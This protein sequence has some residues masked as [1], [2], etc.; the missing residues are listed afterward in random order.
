MQNRAE[1]TCLSISPIELSPPGIG[2]ATARAGG[3]GVLDLEFC[4][5]HMF[6]LARTNLCQLL[7]LTRP[8]QSIGLRLALSRLD[9]ATLDAFLDPLDGRAQWLVLCHWQPNVL[10]Q[11][12]KRLPTSANRRILLE[13]TTATQ[14]NALPTLP[15]EI[16]GLL[17]KGNECGGWVGEDSAFV[18]TQKLL[19]TSSL[20]VYVQ[21][22][23]GIHTAAACRGGGAAGVV[24]DDGLWLMPE[25]P[26][27]E[28]WKSVL[29]TSAGQDT[30]AFGATN[31]VRVL[32][33]PGFGAVERLQALRDSLPPQDERDWQQVAGQH[34]GWGAPDALA[35]PVGQ[36]I[37][38][39][40]TLRQRYKTT[41][42][43]LRALLDHSE[44]AVRLGRKLHVLGPGGPLASAHATTYPILQGPMT[45]VSDTERFA[46][47]VAQAGALPLLALALMQ[48]PA[49][50]RLLNATKACLGDRPWGVGIL[51]FVPLELRQAQLEVVL[52]IRPHIAL[53][54]GG[55]PDQALALEQQGIPTYL[56]VPAP[57]LARL[58]VEQGAKRLIF[59]G[60]ECGGHV[61]PLGSF[62]LWDAVVGTLLDVVP[63][64]AASQMHLLFAGGIHDARSARMIEALSAPLAARGMK[65]G[66]LMGTAYL[67]TREA[68][69]SG[70]IASGFQ[71]QAIA[72]TRTVNLETGPGHASR[73]ALTPFA[74]TFEQTGRRLRAEGLN[75]SEVSQALDKLCLG[76]LRVAAKG[77]TR[78]G[79]ALIDVAPEA[80]LRD[81]MYMIG[82][83]ATM[84]DAVISIADLHRAVCERPA[85]EDRA[86]RLDDVACDT[87][88]TKASDIAIIGI[89]TILPR[90]NSP[91]Q[92]WH[93]IL[94]QIDAVSEIPAARWDWRL[95][96][97]ADPKKRDKV[98]SKWG[99]FIDEVPFNPA[100][101]G[102]PPKSLP[103]IDPI[104]LLAL[105]AVRRAL[106]DAGYLDGDFDRENTAVILGYSGGIGELGEHYV[107][108]SELTARF[109][110]P[111][112]ALLA[113][114]PEWTEDS[115]PGILP[116]VSAGRVTNRF[117]LGGAN[118][119][120]DSA[121]ASSLTAID[122]AVSQLESGRCNLAIA[123]GVDTKLS[124]FGYLCF[125]KTPA[126]TPQEHSHPFDSDADGILLG[127]GVAMVILKRLADAEA[128][129][130]R[131]Y[132][133]IK[134]AASSSDGKALGLTAPRSR[135]Q[136]KA[137]ERAYRKAGFG[138]DAIGLYEAHGTGTRLGDETELHS[139]TSIL[140]AHHA[141]PRSCAVGSVKALIGHTKSTAGAAALIK[142]ALSLYSRTLPPQPHVR[143][144]LANLSDPKSPVY[145][146]QEPIPWLQHTDSPRRAGVSA[147]GFGGTNC[148]CV[149]EEYRG[150]LHLSAPGGQ[151]WPCEL[152]LLA[153][154]GRDALAAQVARLH[155]RLSSADTAPRLRDI[156]RDCVNQTRDAG[157]HAR[158][159]L[160]IVAGDMAALV[161]ALAQTRAHLSAD[162]SPPLPPHIQ[163]TPANAPTLR[164]PGRIAFL[165]PGQGAQ[166]LNMAREVTLLCEPLRQSFEA[167]DQA[168]ADALTQPI[169]R[170]VFPRG[171]HGDAEQA[172]ATRALTATDIAQPAIGVVEA[173]YLALLATLG[174]RPDM[175]GGHSYGEYAAL[176]AA[177]VLS[178]QDFLRLSRARGSAMAAAGIAGDGTMAVV[179][180]SREEVERFLA[181]TEVVLANHNAPQ[182][183]VISGR[184]EAVEHVLSQMHAAGLSTR[185]LPV[186]GAFHS[187][188]MRD[189][190]GILTQAIVEVAMAR[191]QIPVYSNIDARPYPHDTEAIR[192]HLARHMLSPV[193]FVAQVNSMHEAGARCFVEVGPKAILTSLVNQIL[194][195]R[196]H[197]AVSVDGAG[198]GLR[199]LLIALGTLFVHGID[200][201]ISVL[202]EARDS[203]PS[204][205]QDQPADAHAAQARSP[206]W[207]V[208]GGGV[209]RHDQIAQA[210]R[211]I[212]LA[213]TPPYIPNAL[214]IPAPMNEQ[215]NP[216]E[217][218]AQTASGAND[219]MITGTRQAAPFTT[220]DATVAAY[221][222]YQE[223]MQQFLAVQERVM[224]RFLG[225]ESPASVS[226]PQ[227][228]TIPS[229]PGPRAHPPR[230][231]TPH[232]DEP[233]PALTPTTATP[234]AA[235]ALDHD[236]LIQRLLTVVSECTGYPPDMLGLDQALEAELG[237]DSIKRVEILAG[238]ER[239]LPP[240]L[241]T[242]MSAHMEQASRAGTINALADLLLRLAPAD[243]LPAGQPPDPT[244]FP[245]LD[246]AQLTAQV[247]GVVSECTGYPPEMLG[248]DQA[249]EAELGIDSIKRV[250]I[251]AAIERALPPP[252]ASAMS[253]HM[254]QVSRAATINA[255]ADLLLRLAPA[256][257]LPAGQPPEPTGFPVLDRAQ[258][259]AQV[260]GVVSECTGY[261]PEMLGLDQA[262]EAEL[263]IDSIKRVEI[264]AAIERALP[265]PLASAMSAHMEQ[266]SRAATLNALADTL[267]G[268]LVDSA[269][270]DRSPSPAKRL[271]PAPTADGTPLAR[272]DR[273][274][275]RARPAP[276]VPQTPSPL[277]GLVLVT[278]DPL[279][280]GQALVARL[281]EYGV[282][283][284]LL[285]AADS[286]TPEA[287]A[288]VIA[289]LREQQGPVVR[290]VHLAGLAHQALPD[291]LAQWRH[292]TERQT[293][294]LFEL[295]KLCADDLCAQRGRVLS[296]SMLGGAF[297][298]NGVCAPALPVSAGDLGL[299]KTLQLELPEVSVRAVDVA[300]G[301]ADALV[302][303]LVDE[304][305]AQDQ[306]SE[307]GYCQEQRS[308]FEAVKENLHSDA[309]PQLEPA[310][311]WVVLA[312]GG[313]RGIT[314]AVLKGMVLPGMTLVLVGL[315]P[316]PST[317]SEAT[318]GVT[319]VDALR[320]LFVDAARHAQ[321]TPTPV[322]IDR[323]I[324]QLLREREI[325]VNLDTFAAAGARVE[326]HAINVNDAEALVATLDDVYQRLGRIDA[327]IQGVGVIEDKLLRNKSAA[328]FN[329][330]FDT[331]VDSTYLLCRHLRPAS[332]KLALLFASIAG[333]TGNRG[334][335]DY[336]SANEVI[337][338]FAW[339]MHQQWPH[340]RVISINWGPW[341]LTGMA[342]D[343][344]NRQFRERGVIPIP[345]D[346]G[347]CFVREEIAHGNPDDVEIIAGIFEVGDARETPSAL[348][349]RETVAAR[350]PL[351]KALPQTRTDGST[352]L[353]Y[354]FSLTHAHYL[355]D[356]R[357]DGIP[358]VP[359]AVAME[360]M[361]Q[362]VQAAWP[363]WCVSEV[364]DLRVLNGLTLPHDHDR[365]VL[366]QARS[367]SH[368]SADEVEVEA[369]IRDA[370]TDRV[371]Y[372]S[373]LVLRPQPL[374]ANPTERTVL[375][376]GQPLE[377]R[378]AY[379]THC[380]HGPRFQLLTS[381]ARVSAEGVDGTMVASRPSA[382]IEGASANAS[383][384][385]DPG[386]IDALLQ[387]II[388]RSRMQ[389]R[390]YPLPSRFRRI[391]HHG[392]LVPGQTLTFTNRL[393]R[394]T[395]TQSE[396]DFH[397][398]DAQG[399]LLFVLEGIEFS[400]S[401]ELN[402]LAPSTADG[403]TAR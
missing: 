84:R 230:V 349:A 317:E 3:V 148:H 145:L 251:L 96:Y 52:R 76:R 319:D 330:V 240:P 78:E 323:Q 371:C 193:E 224:A 354:R 110:D 181:G 213:T 99:C 47:A 383:W 279:A 270:D 209:R 241:A 263:G 399:Q 22:G 182:Q 307:I 214:P 208:S 31:S 186:S 259:T 61:G 65:V 49:V 207:F 376:T 98:Y 341:D 291:D 80:Q 117:D 294:R 229:V 63:E 210:S 152:I 296:V 107:A 352:H 273:Y 266:V 156:A 245:V 119:T 137:F 344:V 222:A 86:T 104:Q 36:G 373:T 336:A 90:A 91:R 115:F 92:F 42:R 389:K 246:R 260:I 403:D 277:G 185:P 337:N 113:G 10:V 67:F 248:L 347:C 157:A 252:L 14:L 299:L 233:A 384:I 272:V 331:K 223:T 170:Y 276:L 53:I 176:H 267:L 7:R 256:D 43:Y 381:L 12:L 356:H 75:P 396:Q 26:L 316:K 124:P 227:F 188:L 122:V 56:H 155:E 239:A 315:S 95:Y 378:I 268:L 94:N 394:D 146:L 15:P 388:I 116:N 121:C 205:A 203:R 322:E 39:A 324:R 292:A 27:P 120:V 253:A 123:G 177:G 192:D 69:E 297:G 254:E 310:A 168:L 169:S 286:Q 262:L 50:E 160:A 368:A 380:F 4:P 353:H 358:V 126:L 235:N 133:V 366:L 228:A 400:H 318:R 101:F 142:T 20:P 1:F 339:W 132:A 340:T 212:R 171:V 33:R 28:E 311:D 309:P 397:V 62:A 199:G 55:R 135:G 369:E 163:L 255:L 189:S 220:P 8:D 204:D 68:V 215:T 183:A 281:N 221:R 139:I 278:E 102:I 108:R 362:F 218:L 131:I 364:R 179:S 89:S 144:P 382:W 194:H 313:A 338:R 187:S 363:D 350:Y 325:R 242:A 174:L 128:D 377:T 217:E 226:V 162:Q 81:G 45:R 379:G 151:R 219:A 77:I 332:L 17:A 6:D 312:L 244:G 166:Y 147:F 390:N 202:L 320:R 345:P 250:E 302:T 359:A 342:S 393:I 321:Q 141:P 172:A 298:R 11:Q 112:D 97:D 134:A 32:K 150:Q 200:I 314:A 158:W 271:P 269:D 178:R 105:E 196:P 136:L 211:P 264:L 355:D 118:F 35:W 231:A 372:R 306:A 290:L 74:T 261:P 23:I 195:D 308:V 289:S 71:Q 283:T 351:L 374:P 326:Y 180:A 280:I 249:L 41:G 301:P 305:F 54:A 153:A 34:I 282:Q 100:R 365:E 48:P 303:A 70:A 375:A 198:G 300:A 206:Q 265:P 79:S 184:R 386:V 243:E 19:A 257:E 232:T 18:L 304:L 59:E 25:S 154:A 164:E 247:V 237:I 66:V 129:G 395:N 327:L 238:V 111:T 9:D 274:V 333:R 293:K 361:A 5:P 29:R 295:I 58:F 38:Q 85:D 21:G 360:L 335:C 385:F 114:L 175:V 334:Q 258:L 370:N 165:F 72:C 24:L 234:L 161:G 367:A 106:D 93:N 346:A 109:A 2:L 130:D 173:G 284:A 357:L 127:E 44:N 329:R 143:T 287:L 167:A 60:R 236:A 392:T 216:P 46:E 401:Q 391:V 88:S 40:A 343:A 387:S 140:S 83:V 275:M 37:G 87:S 57:A 191:P 201:D 149:L 51:G 16:H 190:Q 225:G 159:R 82:Q 30:V 138:P 348:M 288:Q 402:R 125:S 64:S 73:C 285:P 13:V 103:A 328:S 398:W 197:L